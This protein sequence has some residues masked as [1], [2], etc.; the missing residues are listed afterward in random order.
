MI[1]DAL[2]RPDA[3]LRFDQ[4]G[5]GP[6]ALLLHA[7]GERR[8]VWHKIMEPLAQCG[9]LTVAYDQRGHGESG[10]SLDAPLTAFGADTA[11]MIEHLI[12]PVVVGASLGGFAALSSLADPKVRENV[13]GLVLVDVVPDP[14][15][16]RTRSFLESDGLH[17]SRAL[18]IGDIL[19]RA[20]SLRTAA[21]SLDMPV[22]MIRAGLHSPLSDEDAYRFLKLVPHATIATIAGA[23]HL[24]ARDKPLE[25]AQAIGDFLLQDA[26][27][28]RR[29]GLFLT[30]SGAD[31]LCHPGG[32]L[33][34]HLHRTA[35]T[36]RNW[37]ASLALIDAGR[38]HAAYGTD[39][40][41]AALA[42]GTA[43]EKIVAVVGR[44]AETIIDCY[45]RCDRD[46]S[47][48]TWHTDT[49]ML[50]DRSTGA[51]EPLSPEMRLAL[52][53]LTVANELDVIEHDPE[54]AARFGAPLLR[55]FA[56]WRPFLGD[57]A[58]AAISRSG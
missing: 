21:A 24:V 4:L 33:A 7:G 55:L 2:I 42:D 14:D 44:E 3:V 50:I 13:A 43:R 46:R 56:R 57:G 49:P 26:V 54:I 25:L 17:R 15:P 28:D 29:I 47:Y 48:P 19:G 39:G 45:C 8:R 27:R 22:L 38:L 32:T 1:D 35:E 12:S 52:I 34:R 16:V 31:T 58:R 9:F 30:H 37:G 5:S 18:L 10:G 36:L 11:A 53:E 51:H 20:T 23:G 40:F 41:L 6:A